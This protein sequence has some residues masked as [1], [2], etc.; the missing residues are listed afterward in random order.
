MWDGGGSMDVSRPRSVQLTGIYRVQFCQNLD[1]TNCRQ[2]ND[3]DGVYSRVDGNPP[4]GFGPHNLSAGIY[5]SVW[6]ESYAGLKLGGLDVNLGCDWAD[7]NPANYLGGPLQRTG[8]P[9]AVYYNPKDAVGSPCFTTTFEVAL[10]HLDRADTWYT[11]VKGDWS[12]GS[13]VGHPSYNPLQYGVFPIFLLPNGGANHNLGGIRMGPDVSFRGT[14]NPWNIGLNFQEDRQ[15]SI[16][17]HELSHNLQARLGAGL[18]LLREGH[19]DYM[20]STQ[21]RCVNPD[22]YRRFDAACPGHWAGKLTD[23]LETM[24]TTFGK[25]F[26]WTYNAGAAVFL[27]FD[28]LFPVWGGA[29]TLF[30]PSP[31]RPI[32]DLKTRSAQPLAAA[33]LEWVAATRNNCAAFWVGGANLPVDAHDAEMNCYAKSF[34]DAMNQLNNYPGFDCPAEWPTC[35][36]ADFGK[37]LQWYHYDNLRGVGNRDEYN[38]S[39]VGDPMLLARAFAASHF[40]GHMQAS[41]AAASPTFWLTSS[42]F[43]NPTAGHYTVAVR[44]E[45]LSSTQ[46]QSWTGGTGAAAPDRLFVYVSQ[47]GGPIH[48]IGTIDGD[49]ATD[50]NNQLASRTML[51]ST[52]NAPAFA[53]V[54]PAAGAQFVQVY[55]SQRPKLFSVD[56]FPGESAAGLNLSG[57]NAP[58][59]VCGSPGCTAASE[60]YSDAGAVGGASVGDSVRV[61]ISGFAQ[62]A[63]NDMHGRVLPEIQIGGSPPNASYN[64]IPYGGAPGGM[65]ALTGLDGFSNYRSRYAE[66]TDRYNR[67][68]ST[69]AVA[70]VEQRQRTTVEFNVTA[71]IAQP[72]LRLRLIGRPWIDNVVAYKA[73]TSQHVVWRAVN[74]RPWETNYFTF[75]TGGRTGTLW[76]DFYG[77]T[78]GN[79]T[80]AFRAHFAAYRWSSSGTWSIA[81][82]KSWGRTATPVTNSLNDVPVGAADEK[83]FVILGAQTEPLEGY[84]RIAIN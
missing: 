20:M 5:R 62:W 19:S 13:L 39:P 52:R 14:A 1:G 36:S 10:D 24:S 11:F 57:S 55:R 74:M 40:D 84:L 48:L 21:N 29:P 4:A 69:N 81:F 79:Q 51:F 71:Q 42:Q 76:V 65:I 43:Q 56:V 45:V 61:R 63:P 41:T 66:V 3:P 58:G 83:V 34:D 78:P 27:R 54:P 22:S 23:P 38:V 2:L 33:W 67:F 64:S 46:N 28:H 12:G 17:V 73:P 30:Q 80:K 82:Q 18:G 68:V 25:P 47:F 26:D 31:T 15:F 32:L 72:S 50:G 9:F 49:W 53:T 16:L 75:D 60:T 8:R 70:P 6:I 37:A 44:A 7:R 59:A 35:Y 77:V